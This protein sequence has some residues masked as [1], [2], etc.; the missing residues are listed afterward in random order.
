MVQPENTPGI[1]IPFFLAHPR[2]MRLEKKMIL[3]VEGGTWSEC[4]GFSGM[5][6]A[7]SCSMRI[8]FIAAAAG[9]NCS[10][11]R[12]SAIRAITGRIPPAAITSSICGCGTRKAIPTRILPRPSRCGCGR[13]RNWRTRYVGWPALKKLEYVD[14]LMG[15]IAGKRP[16]L[17]HRE[18]VDPLSKLNADARRLLQEEARALRLSIRRRPTTATCGG[19]SPPIRSI[20]APKR[21]LS[22]IRRNRARVRELV[23]KW[24]GE[25]QLTFD[26]VLDDMIAALPRAQFARRRSG[27]QTY[28][29]IYGAC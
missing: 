9:S 16:L 23:A 15:E 4:M 14:E 26:A 6:P 22:F 12:R 28:D 13:A 5:R 19:C 20:A 25:Y 27:A 21:R 3:E 2:L 8:S 7:M 18:K 1:A 11:R 10:A 24:T 17:T 29:G